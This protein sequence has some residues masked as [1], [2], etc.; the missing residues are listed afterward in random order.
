MVDNGWSE[1]AS[2]DMGSQ[3]MLAYKKGDRA[4]NITIVPADDGGTQILIIVGQE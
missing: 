2:I 3:S 1:Q 4:S